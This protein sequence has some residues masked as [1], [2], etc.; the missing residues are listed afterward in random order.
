ME[1]NGIK[2]KIDRAR[3][4]TG[5]VEVQGAAKAWKLALARSARD[6]IGLELTITNLRQTR[7]SLAE[8]LEMP[9]ERAL[10]AMLEG[11]KE[12]LGLLVISPEILAGIVEIQMIGRV[13]TSAPIARRPTRTDAAM[14]SGMID[15]ALKSLELD[16]T[17]SNDLPWASGFRYASFLEDARPLALL[18]EDTTFQALM[19]DVSLADG[20][21]V[22]QILL[23]LPADGRGAMPKSVEPPPSRAAEMVFG[24]AL[25]EQIMGAK[26]EIVSVLARVSLPL[27]TILNLKIGEPLVLNDATLDKICLEGRDG[28]RLAT[29]KLG[30]NGGMRAIRITAEGEMAPPQPVASVTKPTQPN[31]KPSTIPDIKK[32]G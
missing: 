17:Q 22:G 25:G 4:S 30:Q 14:V 21:R 19:A 18:L 27:E 9:P 31:A 15:K 6:T 10:L 32:A 23:A 28:L 16:L 13:N 20:A 29:G 3:K 11:P 12:G 5:V 8:L 2:R 24:A 1:Q 7:S 26:A